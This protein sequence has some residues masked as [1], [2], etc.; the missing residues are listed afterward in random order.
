MVVLSVHCCVVSDALQADNTTKAPF[1]RCADGE[2]VVLSPIPASANC[3]VLGSL[4][5]SHIKGR[6]NGRPVAFR[7]SSCWEKYGFIVCLNLRPEP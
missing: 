5:K 1:D 2:G 3:Q 4:G 7:R 6:L